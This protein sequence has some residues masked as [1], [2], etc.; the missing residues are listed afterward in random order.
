MSDRMLIAGAALPMLCGLSAL[1]LLQ[2]VPGT[3]LAHA[4]PATA[5]VVAAVQPTAAKAK[6]WVG[7]VVAG[8]TAELAANAPSRVESVFVRTGQTVKP[9]ERLVQ[10]D[11]SESVTSVGMANAQLDQRASEVLRSQARAQAA[12]DNLE[13][14]R[15]G[16]TWLS[17]QELANAQAELK[18]A[19]AELQSA[20]AGI[21]VSRAQLNQQ[22]LRVTHQTLTAPF[23]G[24]VVALDVDA[25]DSVG[26]GQIVMRILSQDRQVRFAFAA[27]ELSKAPGARVSVR[28]ADAEDRVSSVETSVSAIRPEVDPSAQLVFATAQLPAVLPEPERWIPGAPVQVMQVSAAAHEP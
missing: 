18:V 20:Q 9:G 2:R 7:V 15:A 16:E 28:L 10:F 17:K 11:R 25:G 24:T 22:R 26:A 5:A 19:Q 13:R 1:V 14:L 27:G 23:A 4:A 21:G 8:S 6:G 3:P 12:A